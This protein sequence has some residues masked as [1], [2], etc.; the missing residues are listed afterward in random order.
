VSYDLKYYTTRD[1][2][3]REQIF[4]LVSG[5]LPLFQRVMGE[6]GIARLCGMT[7][8][9]SLP[10]LQEAYN[11][12]HDVPPREWNTP[13]PLTDG[14]ARGVIVALL[15]LARSRPEGEWDGEEVG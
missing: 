9:E 12:L 15:S 7:G 6:R 10:V 2:K 14:D 13:G 11:A 5:Y 1:G 4:L 8:Q 3:T